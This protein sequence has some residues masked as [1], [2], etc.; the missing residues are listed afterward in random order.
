MSEANPTSLSVALGKFELAEANLVR[1]EKAWEAILSLMPSGISFGGRS[2]EFVALERDI[3]Q[4]VES[5]PAIDGWTLSIEVPDPDELAQN[6]LDAHEISEPAAIVDAEQVLWRPGEAIAEYRHRLIT[7]KRKLVRKRARKLMESIDGRLTEMVKEAPRDNNS[8]VENA[9]WQGLTGE[10]SELERLLGSTIKHDTGA[11]WGDFRRHLSFAQGCDLHDIAEM[12][13]PSVRKDFEAALYGD[14]EPA[15][16]GVNDLGDLVREHPTGAVSS[17]LNWEAL[18]ARDFERLIFELISSTDGYE[19]TKLLMKTNAPDRSRDV[20]TE[21]VSDDLSGVTRQRII[22]QCKHWGDKSVSPKD[23]TEAKTAMR[24]WEPPP[25]D[26]LIVTTTGRFTVD[27][28]TLIEKNN[29]DGERPRIDM[30]PES[31]LERL[32]AKRPD[33]VTSFNLRS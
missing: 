20:S 32:L 30:W 25:I 28:V 19:N 29:T 2:A 14:R 31:H 10:I 7:A 6:R 4:L 11:R 1:L 9:D 26:V 18:D 3:D 27:A 17:A 21:R 12:D 24:L 33:I 15:E 23:V 22:I 16:V 13:W 8:L 5:L